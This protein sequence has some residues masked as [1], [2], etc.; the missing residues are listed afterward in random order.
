MLRGLRLSRLWLHV[1]SCMVNMIFMH[2]LYLHV[3]L[4]GDC[5]V[6]QVGY[7]FDKF[8]FF[9][10]VHNVRFNVILVPCHIVE[11]TVDD[12]ATSYLL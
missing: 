7:T 4:H 5:T 11:S 12:E 6:N 3:V 9:V 8:C 2:T 10:H 1:R